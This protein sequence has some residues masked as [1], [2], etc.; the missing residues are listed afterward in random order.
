MRARM[1]FMLLGLALAT[2]LQA[3]GNA[4]AG[5]DRFDEECAECHSLKAGKNKK[6]PSLAGIMGK[7]A[8]QVPDFVYSDALRNLH[9]PWTH[10]LLDAYLKFPR[11]AVPGGKMKYD[12]LPDA[13]ARADIIAFLS[14]PE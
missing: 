8:G 14:A 12:G 3:A 13:Q 9:R 4:A 11:G 7:T 5:S 2:P 6:G 1:A 10:D